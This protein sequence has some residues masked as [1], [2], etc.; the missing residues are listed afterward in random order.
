MNMYEQWFQ[1]AMEKVIPN[2]ILNHSAMFPGRIYF[3]ITCNSI[4][5]YQFNLYF[6]SSIFPILS[7][8]SNQLYVSLNL[9]NM[10]NPS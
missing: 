2:N 7:N 6:S 5:I 4:T 1:V 8:Y 10:I 9:N 3:W